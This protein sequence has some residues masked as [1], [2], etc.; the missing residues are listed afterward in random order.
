VTI[1][2][3]VFIGHGVTF[4]NDRYPRATTTNGDL[5]TESDWH[6]ETTVVKKGASVGSGA[7]ILSNLTIG[8][9]AIIGAGSVV[10]KDVPDNAVVVGNPARVI[11]VVDNELRMAK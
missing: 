3:S 9:N 5:Q 2:E 6:L 8:E 7:T 4:I 1:E 11:R 10:T